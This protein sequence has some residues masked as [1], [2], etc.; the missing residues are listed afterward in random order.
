MFGSTADHLEPGRGWSPRRG[1]L[2]DSVISTVAP[3]DRDACSPRG[4]PVRG[5]QGSRSA[6]SGRDGQ[7]LSRVGSAQRA[8]PRDPVG[9]TVSSVQSELAIPVR[10]DGSGPL[11]A[12]TADIDLRPE[13][14]LI[15]WQ[16][17]SSLQISG[18]RPRRAHCRTHPTTGRSAPARS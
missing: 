17:H 10:V 2:G 8:T 6:G 11:P 12:D 3:C 4:S 16:H 9:V 15:P 1:D 7:A 13:P 5:G 14:R 18:A